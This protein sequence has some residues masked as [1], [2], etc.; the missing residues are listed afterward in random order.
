MIL[1]PY[2]EGSSLTV[3]NHP[4]DHGVKLHRAVEL[5]WVVIVNLK[6]LRHNTLIYKA[7]QAEKST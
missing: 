1:V 7:A 4:K 2:P 5:S 3:L 6:Q